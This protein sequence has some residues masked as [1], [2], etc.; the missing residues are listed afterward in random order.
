M[1]DG[2]S[3]NHAHDVPQRVRFAVSGSYPPPKLESEHKKH[4]EG[5]FCAARLYDKIV[6]VFKGLANRISARFCLPFPSFVWFL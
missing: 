6:R 5:G 4:P 3:L 2:G 1:L